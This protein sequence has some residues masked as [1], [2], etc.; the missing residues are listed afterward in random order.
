MGCTRITELVHGKP[1]QIGDNF[2][3]TSYQFGHFPDSVL[4]IEADGKTILNANDC[5]TMGLPASADPTTSPENR[6][7]IA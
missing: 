3:I 5:K 2:R 6:F 4:V 7:R 1:C